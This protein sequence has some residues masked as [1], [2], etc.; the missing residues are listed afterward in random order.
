M[1]V[2]EASRVLAR[3]DPTKQI[4]LES[5]VEVDTMQ[6]EQTWPTAE[7]LDEADGTVQGYLL[8]ALCVLAQVG[9]SY[10]GPSSQGPLWVLALWV[11][12]VWVLQEWVL[13]WMG[14]SFAGFNSLGLSFAIA[15][16][17]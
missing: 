2:D 4:S 10:L 3:P 12:A 6:D 16:L 5:E 17:V 11:H 13:P 14:F 8:F 15:A 1:D 7:E 9:P